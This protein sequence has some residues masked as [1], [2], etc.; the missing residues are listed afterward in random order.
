[1]ERMVVRLPFI[2]LVVF[3][4]ACAEH[5][6]EHVMPGFLCTENLV[7]GVTVE[8]RD[9]MTAAPAA[10]AATGEVRE[11]DYVD[12][13]GDFGSCATYPELAYLSGAY[14]RAGTYRV[15]IS[16]PGYKEWVRDGVVV[17]ADACHVRTAFLSANLEAE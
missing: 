11:G 1:M 3:V 9:A 15:S 4:T 17:T 6:E 16:K 5:S 2:L 7:A 12:P 13:L 14:E 8:V 10:C